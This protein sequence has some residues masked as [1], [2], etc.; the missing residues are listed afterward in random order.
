MYEHAAQPE[1]SLEKGG[2]G[3]GE[4]NKRKGGGKKKET[5]GFVA[6]S[7]LPQPDFHYSSS[8]PQAEIPYY[9]TSKEAFPQDALTLVRIK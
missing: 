8:R 9:N 2:T 1:S 5:C 3:E 7:L 4:K 6:V